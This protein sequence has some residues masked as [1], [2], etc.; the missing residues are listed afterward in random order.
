MEVKK[1]KMNLERA[2]FEEECLEREL[3]LRKNV[4]RG[5]R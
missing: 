1:K 4:S 2:E 3:N 5:K